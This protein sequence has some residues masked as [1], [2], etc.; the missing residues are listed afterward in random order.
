VS[1]STTPGEVVPTDVALTVVL[2]TAPSDRAE[3]I[4][5]ALLDQ[6]VAACVNILPG[7]TSLY[8]WQGAIEAANEALLVIKTRADRVPALTEAIVAA[9]PYDVPEVLVLPTLLGAGNRAYLA[10]VAAE[11]RGAV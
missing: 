11:A 8:W 4:A 6:R 5:R 10:W 7:A 9:H 1:G 2:C 3:L